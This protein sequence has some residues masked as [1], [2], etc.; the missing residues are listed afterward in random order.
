[1]R[2]DLVAYNGERGIICHED[3]PI[4]R[5][6]DFHCYVPVLGPLTV[7]QAGHEPTASIR[8]EVVQRIR[9]YLDAS[10]ESAC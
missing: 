7:L 2:G 6:V 9:A 3:P 5:C 10:G 1:M 8:E 4:M